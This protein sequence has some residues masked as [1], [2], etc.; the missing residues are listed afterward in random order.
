M[1]LRTLERLGEDP[2]GRSRVGVRCQPAISSRLEPMALCSGATTGRGFVVNPTSQR[3]R[4]EDS[5]SRPPPASPPRRTCRKG[6]AKKKVRQAAADPVAKYSWQDP[7]DREAATL[8][9]TRVSRTVSRPGRVVPAQERGEQRRRRRRRPR[10]RTAG[11][12]AGGSQPA[13]TTPCLR[14][15][16]RSPMKEIARWRGPPSAPLALRI[17]WSVWARSAEFLAAIRGT[18]WGPEEAVTFCRPGVRAPDEPDSSSC[19]AS[20]TQL[21]R[22]AGT[23]T[24]GNVQQTALETQRALVV[25]D[26]LTMAGDVLGDEDLYDVTRAVSMPLGDSDDRGELSRYRRPRSA[27]HG[28]LTSRTAHEASRTPSMTSRARRDRARPDRLRERQRLE[29]R[30]VHLA[31]EDDRVDAARQ[32]PSRPPWAPVRRHFL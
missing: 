32:D 24:P 30:L 15:A 7:S 25:Q 12:C 6:T 3:D 11:A 20:R 4:E 21:V 19:T 2:L 5:Q 16:V 10:A 27:A 26:G 31:D 17:W 23:I 1:H 28:D 13:R 14:A 9:R 22:H 29:S 18:F 8:A